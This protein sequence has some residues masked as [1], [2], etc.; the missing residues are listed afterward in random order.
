MFGGALDKKKKMIIAGVAVAVLV[1]ILAL[2]FGMKKDEKKTFYGSPY[3]RT[4][5]FESANTNAFKGAE[6]TDPTGS[7]ARGISPVDMTPEAVEMLYAFQQNPSISVGGR[8]CYISPTNNC[9]P[10]LAISCGKPG[11]SDDATGEL[12]A[13]GA[14]GAYGAPSLKEEPV[15]SKIMEL[16]YDT[17][18]RACSDANVAGQYA[19]NIARAGT[20]AAS[21]FVNRRFGSPNQRF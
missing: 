19:A 20:T 2:A 4:R 5:H 12:L 13:L 7:T 15:F 16:S 1:L 14:A 11:W 17:V 6:R 18:D 10:D 8:S 3:Q 21:P 9:P